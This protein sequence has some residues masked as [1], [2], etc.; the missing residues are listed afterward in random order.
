[1]SPG[2]PPLQG[3]PRL[4]IASQLG[5]WLTDDRHALAPDCM[6]DVGRKLNSADINAVASW[7]ATQPVPEHT[8]PAASL[9]APL[10]MRC[11]A[12]PR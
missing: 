4:N 7:L 9:A 1:V 2:I 10:P 6:T 8:K 3:L 12:M 11:S 5:S